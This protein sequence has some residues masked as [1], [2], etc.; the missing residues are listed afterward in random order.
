LESLELFPYT[1]EAELDPEGEPPLEVSEVEL[2]SLELL[3]YT[4]EAELDPE[5]E[6][7]LWE[8]FSAN[9]PHATSTIGAP[10]SNSRERAPMNKSTLSFSWTKRAPLRRQAQNSRASRDG[11][12]AFFNGSG[13]R[14]PSFI[15]SAKRGRSE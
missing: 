10:A 11:V 1:V 14:E 13:G 9:D 4:V 3:P 8:E 15:V 7:P 5:G 2:E 12:D 6:P